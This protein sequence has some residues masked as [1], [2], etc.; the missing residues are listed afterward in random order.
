MIQYLNGYLK[1]STSFL[2]EEKIKMIID[3]LEKDFSNFNDSEIQF[4]IAINISDIYFFI[5]KDNTKIGKYINKAFQILNKNSEKNENLNLLIIL[6]NKILYYG[7]K[8]TRPFYI[9]IINKAIKILQKSKLVKSKEIKEKL[10]EI[11]IHYKNT[12]EY[13]IKKKNQ[14]SNP[15]YDSILI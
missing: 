8:E 10:K 7:E 15:L 3:L 13:I 2:N 12:I 5:L 9:E 11:Y 1:S 4:K 14:K 6:I